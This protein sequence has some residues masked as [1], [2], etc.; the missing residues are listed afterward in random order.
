MIYDYVLNELYFETIVM[1]QGRL[2]HSHQLYKFKRNSVFLLG[3]KSH[4]DFY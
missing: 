3:L 1:T 4:T 2:I